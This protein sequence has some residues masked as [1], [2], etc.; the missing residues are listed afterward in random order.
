MKTLPAIALGLVIGLCVGALGSAVYYGER[1]GPT[2]QQ[3][4]AGFGFGNRAPAVPASPS[5]KRAE[6]AS[7]PAP[8]AAPVQPP[9]EPAY[10]PPPMVVMATPEPPPPP[11][12]E[13]QPPTAA[14]TKAAIEAVVSGVMNAGINEMQ[15]RKR[16]VERN[17]AKADP[18]GGLFALMDYVGGWATEGVK[19]AM[20]DFSMIS[21]ERATGSG[22]AGWNVDVSYNLGVSGDTP[23]AQLHQRFAQYDQLPGYASIHSY[24]LVRQLDG[25]WQ[26]VERQ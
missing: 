26:A 20:K 13:E 3:M 4:L 6:V 19:Y 9:P 7:A 16:A 1:A 14:E 25:R 17:G 8:A 10:R 5:P 2:G 15:E 11:P 23:Q 12:V 22:K 24:R 21:C 18:G